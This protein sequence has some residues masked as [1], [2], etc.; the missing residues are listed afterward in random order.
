MPLLAVEAA[1]L[2]IEDR[3]RGVI[4]EI[5][6]RDE[7]FALLPFTR[8]NDLTYSY[9]REKTAAQ[10]AW[11]SAYEVLEES[12]SEFDPVSVTLKRL[13]GQVDIDNFMDEVQSALNPQTAIQLQ[14]KIKGIGRQ[15][16]DALVNGDTATNAKMFDGLKKLTP[17]AQTMW[18]GTNGGAI[19]FTQLDELKDMVKLGCDVLMMRQGTW[20]ALRALNRAMGGNTA[21]HIM[22][23]NFGY[24]VKAYDGTPVIINDYLP[25]NEVRGTN[26]ATTSIYALRLNEADGFHGLYG[27]AA[28]GFRMEKIGL[29]QDK[30]ATRYRIK[31]YASTALK[32]T[33]AIARLGGITNI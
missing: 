16:R 7:M 19:S 31:W 1:K 14:Q 18:A 10:G 9:V 33:H 28:A 3:Q 27:G 29:L 4:E 32:A 20:R 2:S 11:F 30:D 17:A 6:D 23:E 24:P 15:F 8:S 13:A 21:D 5:I 26:P 25:I 22:V 12:A